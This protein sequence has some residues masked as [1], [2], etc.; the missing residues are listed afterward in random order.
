[1]RE[2]TSLFQIR[3]NSS[4]TLFMN[5]KSPWCTSTSSETETQCYVC[6]VITWNRARQ[7]CNNR[8]HP[9][10]FRDDDHERAILAAKMASLWIRLETPETLAH[11]DFAVSIA[12]TQ[13]S[14]RDVVVMVPIA[15]WPQHEHQSRQ[16][17]SSC[18]S[19]ST[20]KAYLLEDSIENHADGR[21][22]AKFLRTVL[23]KLIRCTSPP[24]IGS[25][26]SEL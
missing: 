12:I 11:D 3:I 10:S 13:I 14:H 21:I 4:I 16:D 26:P 23:N 2:S 15:E 5:H 20:S 9:S 22:Q 6:A 24:R 1:M 17:P 25:H 7:L 8:M 18:F 19:V